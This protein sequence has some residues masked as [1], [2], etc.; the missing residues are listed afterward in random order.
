MCSKIINLLSCDRHSAGF[1]QKETVLAYKTL[2]I[3]VVLIATAF[4]SSRNPFSVSQNLSIIQQQKGYS[5]EHLGLL[6]PYSWYQFWLADA[7]DSQST[8]QYL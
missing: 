5:L 4:S 1:H 2:T 3:S 7:Q 8:Q 6:Q